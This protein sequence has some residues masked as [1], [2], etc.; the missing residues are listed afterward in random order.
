MVM[1][2]ETIVSDVF[3]LFVSRTRAFNEALNVCLEH[4]KVPC[5]LVGSNVLDVY[6]V[7]FLPFSTLASRAIIA[8]TLSLPAD[9]I[10]EVELLDVERRK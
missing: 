2:S 8:E 5:V 10:G 7:Q 6:D 3:K 1:T 4:E 9:L